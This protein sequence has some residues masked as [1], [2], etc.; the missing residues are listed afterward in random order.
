MTQEQAVV[1]T[2]RQLGGVASLS[3][4]YHN[5][6]QITDCKWRTKTPYA[7]IRAIVQRAPKYIYKIKPGLYG[8]VAMKKQLEENGIVVQTKKNSKCTEV[9]SFNHAYYQSLLLEIGNRRRFLT[10]VPN[11]DKNRVVSGN[12][13]L[14][15][16]S[17]C[18]NL[19]LF[20]TESL[21][22]R[23]ETIDV[24]WLNAC[25]DMPEYFFEVEHSTDIQNS[26]LKYNDLRAFSAKMIIVADGKRRQEFEKKKNFSSFVDIASRVNFLEYSSLEKQYE[27]MLSYLEQPVGILNL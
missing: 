22:R 27:L 26:L 15:E 2:I 18:L 10:H 19:P 4:I 17:T 11:Q 13:K 7:S 12:T 16:L 9:I 20:T 1:E 8:L 6:F 21:L 23:A 25:N 24:M 3:Q 14:S 5:I